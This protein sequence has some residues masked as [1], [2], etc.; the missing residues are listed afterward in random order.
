MAVFRKINISFW[1]D[2]KVVD[3]VNYSIDHSGKKFNVRIP[4]ILGNN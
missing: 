2:V 3:A 1:E 4:K